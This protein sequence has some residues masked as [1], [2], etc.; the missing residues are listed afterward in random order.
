M[1]QATIEQSSDTG[2][3][4]QFNGIWTGSDQVHSSIHSHLQPTAHSR[5]E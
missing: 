2:R 4:V 1:H 5:L 3:S